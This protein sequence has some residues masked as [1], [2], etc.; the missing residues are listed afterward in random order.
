MKVPAIIVCTCL[1]SLIFKVHAA[2]TNALQFVNPEL[3]LGAL[4]NGQDVSM[5]FNLTNCSDQ[6][7]KIANTDTSCRCTS[8]QKAPDEIPAH[9][10]GEL[11]VD[12]NSSRSDGPVTQSV[13]VETARGQIISAQFY[14][15]VGAAAET[16]A[17]TNSSTPSGGQFRR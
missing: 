14:A 10:S 17:A 13:V 1:G 7:V 12:F 4:T 16:V 11:A 9:G 8:V 2:E 6:A 3:Q 15:T 5:T